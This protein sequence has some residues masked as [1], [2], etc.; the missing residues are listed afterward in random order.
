MQIELTWRKWPDHADFERVWSEVLD[1]V[2]G[3]QAGNYLCLEMSD[4]GTRFYPLSPD[5]SFTIT[6][7]SQ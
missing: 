5:L 2:D 4:G 3:A 6:P 1:I 7:R